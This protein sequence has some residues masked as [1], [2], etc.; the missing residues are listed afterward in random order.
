MLAQEEKKEALEDIQTN[1]SMFPNMS[2]KQRNILF[3]A[4]GIVGIFTRLDNLYKIR[5]N[6]TIYRD[7]DGVHGQI[8]S[9]LHNVHDRMA[10]LHWSV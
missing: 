10:A 8:R 7:L 9:L 2:E 6:T 4:T 5:C 3:A 1:E